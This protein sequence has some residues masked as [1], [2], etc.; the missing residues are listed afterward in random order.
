[1]SVGTTASRVERFIKM[2]NACTVRS[3]LSIY[4]SDRDIGIGV[5]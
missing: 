3:N 2:A 5:R 4:F 1:M